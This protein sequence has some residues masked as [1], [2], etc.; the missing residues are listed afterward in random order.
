MTECGTKPT[1]QTTNIIHEKK[2]KLTPEQ[3]AAQ[4]IDYRGPVGFL[5]YL[6]RVPYLT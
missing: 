2:T 6:V 5:I 3:I 1:P 4:I